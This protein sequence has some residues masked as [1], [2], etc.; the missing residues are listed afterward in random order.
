MSRLTL[1]VAAFLTAA[2]GNGALAQTAPN[3][4]AAAPLERLNRLASAGQAAFAASRWDEAEKAYREIVAV[5]EVL[6]QKNPATMLEAKERIAIS[7]WRR[8]R[9]DDAITLLGQAISEANAS[10][11][12][13]R[14]DIYRTAMTLAA[15]QYQDGR[16]AASEAIVSRMVRPPT[17]A[18]PIPASIS[19]QAH[20]L[21]ARIL[22]D[23][24][25]V[26][27]AKRLLLD[28]IQALRPLA[29]PDARIERVQLLIGAAELAI[30]ENRLGEG[31]T[32]Y[33]EALRLGDGIT[34]LAS[35]R[36]R[37]AIGLA[38]VLIALGRY[39]EARNLVRAIGGRPYRQTGVPTRERLNLL[40][41]E[42]AIDLAQG[43][44]EPAATAFS[45]VIA[46]WPR[47]GRG[48]DPIVLAAQNYRGT[49][50]LRR[51]RW[52]D[53]EGAFRAIID[54]T[55]GKQGPARQAFLNAAAKLGLVMARSGRPVEG[56]QIILTAGAKQLSTI[57]RDDSTI[58]FTALALAQTRFLL[59]ESK[60]VLTPAREALRLW[61]ARSQVATRYRFANASYSTDVPEYREEEGRE[62]FETFAEAAWRGSLQAPQRRA[63]LADE[64]FVALQE[65]EVG[66]V[67]QA[68][69]QAGLRDFAE[70]RESGLGELIRKRQALGEAFAA[71][72][73]TLARA[74]VAPSTP[75]PLLQQYESERDAI[76]R[77]ARELEQ[78]IAQ[79]FPEY[80]SFAQPRQ[81]DVAQVQSLL[82]P[83]QALLYVV[84]TRF[85]THAMAITREGIDWHRSTMDPKALG[86]DVSRLLWD[87]DQQ[88]AVAPALAARWTKETG[89][90]YSFDRQRALRLYR[91]L[92]EPLAPRL[93]GKRRVFVV[94][95]GPLSSLPFGIL[96]T[97]DPPGSDS[98]PADLRA[99]AWMADAYE[100]AVLPTVQSLQLLKT[101]PR[102][103]DGA[104]GP[105]RFAGYGNPDLGNAGVARG[106]PRALSGKG[107]PGSI[108]PGH[109]RILSEL[110]RGRFAQIPSTKD[111]LDGMR[112][113]FK[114]PLDSVH[115]GAANTEAAVR[116]ADLRDIQVLAFATHG[117][118]GGEL[119]PG[120][121]PGLVFTLPKIAS[122][123]D[124]GYL[125]ASEIMGMKLNADWVILSACNTAAGDGTTGAP[126]LSGL[127][128]AFFYAGASNLLV[129]HWRV[130]DDPAAII[131]V[132]TIQTKLANPSL[133]RAGALQHAI[134]MVRD[135][136]EN[137]FVETWAHPRAWAPYSLVG[138]GD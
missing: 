17:G 127:A 129:S 8:N 37:M 83:D 20:T 49:L 43:R 136:P 104:S 81:L 38:N 18:A 67:D 130:L 54:A 9:L 114:A 34:Q 61:R 35:L 137:D 7:L 6:P 105:I 33:R 32:A 94:S 98:E 73:A 68:L 48:D 28:R 10:R 110:A 27:H 100:L 79:A 60:D 87:C 44:S 12:V 11:Q 115:L 69:V 90:A 47:V 45:T 42:G 113:A 138:I 2:M 78:R 46:D 132:Q 131:T 121:E 50:A 53:A 30:G 1:L 93:A 103:A 96:V 99:T 112:E 52:K 40:L 108:A 116:S 62:V 85:G 31:E 63:S 117:L 95:S 66:S 106:A 134:K 119:F 55:R 19:G 59:A 14:D 82:G 58:Y 89:G 133:S 5:M 92:I 120:S 13:S 77:D 86:L 21:Y 135:N 29:T 84:P 122:A 126:G 39:E 41:T 24:G 26:E 22:T 124:D 128:R 74:R 3:A 64:A 91:E 70:Q 51:E 65:A 72:E 16:A 118:M 75:Q 102:S 4:A 123:R 88:V 109:S 56:E 71:R 23:R 107:K 101:A 80:A 111:E 36:P 76:L 25:D 97:R 125:E 15:V 57:D